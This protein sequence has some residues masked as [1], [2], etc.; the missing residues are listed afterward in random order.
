MNPRKL[1]Q[2]KAFISYSWSSPDHENWVLTLVKKLRRDGIDVIFDK[3]DLGVGHDK[4]AFMERMVTDKD[5]SKVI[6]I[7]DKLYKEK[8]DKRKGGVGTESQIISQEIY[9]SV[10]Q[11][12][13]IPVVTEY[14]NRFE[15]CLPLFLRNRMFIDLS[16][17]ANVNENY[18]RLL[19][20][21]FDLP[22]HF[23][24]PLGIPPKHI[25]D[26][27]QINYEALRE[28][29]Y[30]EVDEKKPSVPDNIELPH[31]EII[32]EKVDDVPI[33]TQIHQDVLV[34]GK[35]T[36]ES[37]SSFLLKQYKTIKNRKG[38]KYHDN[39]TNVYIYIYD[40]KSKAEAGQGLWLAMLQMSSID[41]DSPKITIKEN[42]I[43]RIG[44]KPVEKFGLSEEI[45]EKIFKELVVSED[46]AMNEAIKV[47]PN[48]IQKQANLEGKLR[49]KYLDDLAK[50]YGLDKGQ[51]LK[52]EVEG[53][54]NQWIMPST[55]EN[56]I[57]P[58]RRFWDSDRI[59]VTFP[60]E[61]DGRKIPCSISFEALEDHF[62]AD[63]SNPL[64]S[65]D[66]NR[67]KIESIAENV[68][69]L[70]HFE[71]DGSILIRTM[72]IRDKNNLL[73]GAG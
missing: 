19:R 62:S 70:E 36:K 57:F 31:F 73:V 10:N 42:Q 65:F 47:Y 34:K 8:A 72:D 66:A 40:Q 50:N 33:K 49:Q 71:P 1:K 38:F 54:E 26:A 59:V 6:I 61:I 25:V 52:I 4:Y 30:S 43:Q 27:F 18:S 17:S 15:P 11:D 29:T 44:R 14:D 16:P 21:L 35:V 32:S 68:I 2:P 48:E 67:S 5:V 22:L 39:P 63:Y 60:A 58:R 53:F 13:F 3:W 56:V 24:S 46:K 45:R 64:A 55:V 20:C 23:K 7:S 51:I 37:L 41:P 69:R 12:K 28:S 9:E